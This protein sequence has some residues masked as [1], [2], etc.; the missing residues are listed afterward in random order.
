MRARSG[1]A[2]AVVLAVAGALAVALVEVG[3]LAR[4]SRIY[5]DGWSELGRFALCDLGLL[6]GAGI[7]AGLV[8]ALVARGV[9]AA[10]GR[11]EAWRPGPWRARLYTAL[12][13]A[14]IAW[15]SAQVFRGPRA[16]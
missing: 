13:A 9:G 4:T 1:V 12:G 5:F 2:D 14:P 10:T 6:A 15:I 8:L 7:L 16:Q 3:W 11:L